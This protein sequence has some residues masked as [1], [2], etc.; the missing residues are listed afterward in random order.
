MDLRGKTVVVSGGTSGIGRAAAM[1]LAGRGAEVIVI[2]R[3]LARGEATE[4]A[5]RKASGGVGDF[6]KADLSLS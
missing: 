1:M 6:L 4:A 2:G 3:D 5:L